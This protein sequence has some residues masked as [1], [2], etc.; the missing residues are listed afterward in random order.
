MIKRCTVRRGMQNHVWIVEMR[1]GKRWK[2]TTGIALSREDSEK[3]LKWWRNVNNLHNRDEYLNLSEEEYRVRK[4][5]AE[6]GK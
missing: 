1:E 5:S 3:E 2:P 6:E 4:Y